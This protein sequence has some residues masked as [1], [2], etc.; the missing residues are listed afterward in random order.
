MRGPPEHLAAAVDE[1]SA[2]IVQPR[3]QSA[4][5]RRAGGVMSWT[6]KD[7]ADLDMIVKRRFVAPGP[8]D[9]KTSEIRRTG[10]D[11]SRT[12]EKRREG[13]DH[14]KIK[15][16]GFSEFPQAPG[17]VG[18]AERIDMLRLDMEHR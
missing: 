11:D 8:R 1:M 6:A 17:A 7:E 16:D 18:E 9:V 4:P 10:I 3:R 15:P 14:R 5:D 13:A 12:G 2:N